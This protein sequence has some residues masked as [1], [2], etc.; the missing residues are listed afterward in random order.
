[1][2]PDLYSEHGQLSLNFLWFC[3]VPPGKCLCRTCSYATILYSI[4]T[5]PFDGFWDND[6]VGK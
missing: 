2:N 6:S 3:S 1:V 5:Q 4:T